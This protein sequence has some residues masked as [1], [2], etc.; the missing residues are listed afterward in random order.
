[1][2]TDLRNAFRLLWKNPGFTAV[3]V[4]TLA[5]GVGAT[6]AIFSVVHAV[7]L[8]PF[9]Y[10]DGNRILFV[11]SSRA[12]QP[13]N[14]MPVAY[15]DFLVW[16]K[17]ARSVDHL[18]F[19]SGSSV[20]LT[21]VPEP[22]V[23]R[24]GAVSAEVWPLLGLQPELG[25]VF[26]AAEDQPGAPAVCVLSHATWQKHFGADPAILGRSVS[27]DSR[28]YT[29]I[30]VMPPRFKFWAGDLWTPVGL[31][32]D[33]DQ[34]R[35]RVM[36]F[37][38]WV[39]TK[40]GPGKTIDDVRAELSVIARQIAQQFPDTNKDMGVH[41][42]YLSESVTGPFRNPL[43]ILLAAVAAVLLIACANVAN[44]FLARTSARRRE[45]AVRAALGASRGQLIRQTLVESL[46][47]ALLG[48]CAGL[49]AAAWGLDGL[50]AILPQEAVPAEAQISVNGS[51]MLFSLT[52]TLG[53][54]LLFSLF[55]ALESSRAA[56]GHDLQEGAKGT[57]GVRTGRVRAGLIVA[58]VGL[59]LVLL[60][61]AGLLVRSLARIASVSVGFDQTNLLVV[62]IQL[63]EARYGGSE[64]ATGFFENAVDRLK[65]LPAVSAVAAATGAPFANVNGM[66]LV[67]EGRAYTDITQLEGLIF[68]GV[69]TDYFKAQ[70]LRLV[71]GRVFADTDRAGSQPVIVLNEAAVKKFVPGGDPLGRRVMLG[72]PDHLIKPGMLPAGFD[73]FQWATVV[74]VV[75]SARYFGQQNEPPAAAYIPIRQ[76]WD[77]P[78]LRRFMLLLV[79]THGRALDFVPVLRAVVKSIDPD[80]PLGRVATMEMLI[81]D[82]LQ[83]T[84]FNTL[85]LGLFAGV[86]LTLS[87]VGIYGLVSWNVTQRTREIGI[88][89]AL[90]AN[91][92]S[93][94]RMVIGQAMRVVLLGLVLGVGG[95]IAVARTMQS[96]LF[97]ISPFDPVT[98][99]AVAGLLG[100]AALLACWLPARRA[101]KV[102]PIEA[103]R[104]E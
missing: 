79:R 87:V 25:R 40:P 45:F 68:A 78:Q 60:V 84:R 81:G 36:R 9:P 99:M 35:S 33:T 27:F 91:R 103:L 98:F 80:L 3:A 50:L 62:P 38:S 90:G 53:T 100:F 70:G 93:V 47:L 89:Q 54:L 46:P 96:L 20:T 23:L 82:S 43:L 6:T 88:R 41:L 66:P 72:A 55:P 4:L 12:D 22:V 51:V 2:L 94:L 28:P 101:T 97:E 104:A 5:L 61:G 31:Q 77:Y 102:D 30:G 42:R 49:G 85:L 75:R 57:A 13:G 37:D 52:V 18:A 48:G 67:V 83:G 64:Q 65:S 16:R 26:T 24:N 7:L 32:A 34:M 63:A 76:A 29:V 56:L 86:A 92:A 71:R 44:L 59:S 15:P 8:H 14:Q 21:G 17:N 69:T 58:E 73:K 10:R 19:A 11:G 74:G 1:M 95:A 39:V